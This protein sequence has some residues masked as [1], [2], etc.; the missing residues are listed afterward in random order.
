MKR[1]NVLGL[2]ALLGF[3][4]GIAA[5]AAYREFFPTILMVFPEIFQIEWVLSGLAGSFLT[6]TMVVLWAYLSK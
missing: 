3:V 4:V 2:F 5:N 6:T 1:L